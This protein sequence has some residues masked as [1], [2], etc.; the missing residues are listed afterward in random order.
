MSWEQGRINRPQRRRRTAVLTAALLIMV[1]LVVACSNATS[2]TVR[3]PL[4][5]PYSFTPVGQNVSGSHSAPGGQIVF[6]DTQFPDTLN[7]LFADMPID[8]T[9]DNALWAA[10]VFFDQQFH[11]HADQLT[12]VP[13]S[14]NGDV[15]DGGK[16]IIMRLR[17][18]LRWSDGQPILASDFAY[19][20]HL[21]QN[22]D[23]GAI[24]TSGYDQIASITTPDAY[25]VILHMKRPFGP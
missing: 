9:L 7:P 24:M 21:D 3:S 14:Q 17:H 18:D 10:P 22:P 12:E 8:F 1:W 4:L 2:P 25:T 11:V 13:L 16:T 6:A 5:G 20:W 19:W 23:T 15:L